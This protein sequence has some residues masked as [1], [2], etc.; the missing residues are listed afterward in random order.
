MK[1][2]PTVWI[3]HATKRHISN[4]MIFEFLV[5]K[6][7]LL[8]GQLTVVVGSSGCGKTTLLDI[9]GCISHF[10][11]CESYHMWDGKK[12]MDMRRSSGRIRARVRRNALGYVLQQGGLLPFL[13]A[14]EN[15]LLPLQ[16]ARKTISYDEIDSLAHLLEI[17]DQLNKYPSALSIGQRQRISIARALLPRPSLLLADEPTGALDPCSA[18]EVKKLLLKAARLANS[19]TVIVTHDTELFAPEADQLLAFNIK[20]QGKLTSSLLYCK[21]QQERRSTWS[22]KR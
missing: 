4:D 15:I 1:H 5:P 3:T 8:P 9:L 14:R 10:D 19:S 16:M 21:F 20:K 22:F 18:Q 17:S 2:Q 13:T 11:S 6:L 7:E 12:M